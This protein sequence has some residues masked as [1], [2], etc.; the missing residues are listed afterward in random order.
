MIK[1]SVII[2]V[3]N[4]EKY[5]K[6]CLD[7]VLK[8]SFQDFELI[9][10]NDCSTDFSLEILE[11]YEKEYPDKVKILINEKNLGLSASRDRGIQEAEGEYIAFFD[12]DDY[13]KPDYLDKYVQQAERTRADIVMGGYIRVVGEKETVI[14]LIDSTYTPWLYPAVWMRLYRR[15]FLKEHDLYFGKYRIYEDSPFNCRCLLEGAQVSVFDYCG[16]YYGCNPASLTKSK[17]GSEKYQQLVDNFRQVFEEYHN[18]PSFQE[19][20]K[21]L[22]YVFL[23]DIV[24]CILL[25]SRHSGKTAAYGMYENYRIQMQ[26]MFPE[27]KKNE[28]IGFGKLKEGRKKEQYATAAFMLAERMGL[29]KTLIRLISL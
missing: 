11:Y 7:S 2:P 28:W 17:N 6:R 21:I 10:V 14:D 15:E 8:Q 25:Q 29:G 9:C 3:Y 26:E 24:C 12:S 4:V 1:V 13:V 20:E 5:L 27:Y 19:N 22:E 23:S 18:K 16:Y